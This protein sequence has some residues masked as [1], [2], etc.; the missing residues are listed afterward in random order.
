MEDWWLAGCVAGWSDGWKDGWQRIGEN[1]DTRCVHPTYTE[2]SEQDIIRTDISSLA[3]NR[4]WDRA[5]HRQ[6]L[7]ANTERTE[8]TVSMHM[9]VN[10]HIQ[11]QS[12]W[13]SVNDFKR[14]HTVAVTVTQPFVFLSSLFYFLSFSVLCYCTNPKH[15]CLTGKLFITGSSR[16]AIK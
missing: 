15:L 13:G 10:R 6:V 8:N 12:W 3:R 9:Y 5:T 7:S 1:T 16:E 4:W 2:R 14:L 11:K